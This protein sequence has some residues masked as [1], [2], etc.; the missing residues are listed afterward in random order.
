MKFKFLSRGGTLD[1]GDKVFASLR[2]DWAKARQVYTLAYVEQ[3]LTCAI[4][5]I[6]RYPATPM[7]NSLPDLLEIK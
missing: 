6:L 1:P 7:Y 3:G 4:D 5:Q 2:C